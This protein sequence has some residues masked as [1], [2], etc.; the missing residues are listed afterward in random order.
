MPRE[1]AEICVA[2][3]PADLCG[4]GRGVIR[5]VEIAHRLMLERD[6]HQQIA[7]LD[8]LLADALSMLKSTRPRTELPASRSAT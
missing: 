7:L 8:A 3:A 1:G 2:E 5:G 6:G 4:A